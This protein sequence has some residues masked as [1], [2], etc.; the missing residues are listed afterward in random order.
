MKELL[1]LSEKIKHP[2]PKTKVRMVIGIG[3]TTFATSILAASF[4]ISRDLAP[5]VVFGGLS[6]GSNTVYEYLKHRWNS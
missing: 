3:S 1:R 4:A 5:T 6:V 2:D